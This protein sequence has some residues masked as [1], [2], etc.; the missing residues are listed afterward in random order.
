V[1]VPTLQPP[2]RPVENNLWHCLAQTPSTRPSEPFPHPAQRPKRPK[3]LRYG[4]RA[5]IT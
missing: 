5:G 3:T 4:E 1:V 2:F